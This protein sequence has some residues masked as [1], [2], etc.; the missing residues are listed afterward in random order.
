VKK[1][2]KEEVAA[3]RAERRAALKVL[4]A[5]AKI[6]FP[7]RRRR[8]RDVIGVLERRIGRLELRV[9]KLSERLPRVR[10]RSA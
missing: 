10:K 4:T 1:Y 2:T 8:Y 6:L 9:K 5:T 7:R 3:A